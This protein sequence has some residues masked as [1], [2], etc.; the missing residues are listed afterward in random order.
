MLEVPEVLLAPAVRDG[1][2]ISILQEEDEAGPRKNRYRNKKGRH[3]QLDRVG[4]S[5][6]RNGR[7]A[8]C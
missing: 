7:S 2:A 5:N 3:L 1:K 4:L 8:R 6:R